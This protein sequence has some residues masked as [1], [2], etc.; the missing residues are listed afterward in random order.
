MRLKLN[1]DVILKERD[2]INWAI[3][4]KAISRRFLTQG[5]AIV[6]SKCT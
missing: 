5:K 3:K 2:V 6:A 4:A 1:A